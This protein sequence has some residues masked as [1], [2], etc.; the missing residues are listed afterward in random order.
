MVVPL[1]PTDHIVGLDLGQSSDYTA[2]AVLE[3]SFRYTDET[4]SEFIADYAVRHLKRWQLKTPYNVIID[5][6]VKLVASPPLDNPRLAVDQTGVGA[7]VVDLLRAAE[8]KAMLRPVL[9]TAGHQITET[10]GEKHVPKKELVSTLQVLLQSRR[11]RVAPLPERELLV[12]ELLAFKVKITLSANETFEAWRERDHDDMVLAVALAAWLGEQEG[13]V[14][15]E[16]GV[17]GIADRGG[18]P[19]VDPTRGPPLTENQRAYRE[20]N[21]RSH[22]DGRQHFGYRDYS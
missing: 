21:W 16:I 20:R 8:P 14:A 15:Y 7:A 4:L 2:L 12:K 18:V 5:E 9:I 13:A 11:L 17:W 10:N 19:G 1:P 3:R 22:R 6:V